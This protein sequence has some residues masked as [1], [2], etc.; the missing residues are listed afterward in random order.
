MRQTFCRVVTL[1]ILSFL[2][3][4][5]VLRASN[6]S[7]IFVRRSFSNVLCITRYTYETDI[8]QAAMGSDIH[9]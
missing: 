9:S 1:D 6:S 7:R 5:S 4:T 3:P 8:T 2:E